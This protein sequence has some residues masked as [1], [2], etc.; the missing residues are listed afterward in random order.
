MKEQYIIINEYG[1][2][3]YFSDKEMTICHREDGPSIESAF[4]TKRWFINN[5]EL[6]ETEFDARKVRK[7][8]VKFKA[9]KAPC[10]GKKVTIDGVEY[11]LT[12][13]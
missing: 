4:G 2:K 12:V 3:F 8:P 1:S 11:V 9:H 7:T 5:I 6:T 10:N 13:K